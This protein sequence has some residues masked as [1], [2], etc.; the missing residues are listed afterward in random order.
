MAVSRT[1]YGLTCSCAQ[2][3]GHH[4]GCIDLETFTESLL[5]ARPSQVLGREQQ[6][7]QTKILALWS[8]S[9]R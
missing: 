4:L 2:M 9:S 1:C 5:Y 3:P 6:T 7:Q 8:S